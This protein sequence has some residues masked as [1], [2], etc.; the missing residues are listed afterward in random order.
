MITIYYDPV[1]NPVPDG[2]IGSWVLEEIIPLLEEG[3]DHE[4]TV[5]TVECLHVLH[6][7]IAF[8]NVP[9]DQFIV[10]K[11]GVSYTISEYGVII[12]AASREQLE[13]YFSSASCSDQ[14]LMKTV[15]RYRGKGA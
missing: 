7:E 11:D 8:G 2:K 4:V 5:A 1:I 9:H 14:I 12:H 6:R 15:E 13:P 3:G 10:I